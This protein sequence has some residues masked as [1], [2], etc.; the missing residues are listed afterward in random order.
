MS[1]SD[2]SGLAAILDG[3]PRQVAWVA[4]DIMLDEYVMG[5]VRRI[6]PEAPV[7]VVRVRDSQMRLGGAANVAAQIATLGGAASLMGVVGADAA[8]DT[9]LETCAARGIDTRA[10]LRLEAIATTR[11]VRVLG[12]RQQ[13]LRLDWEE[14]ASCPRAVSGEML[15][16]LG[17]GPAPD[18]VI[19]SDY[20]KG[21]LSPQTIGEL[22]AAARSRGVLVLVDPKRLDFTAYRGA[23]VITPNLQ[24][25]TAASGRA[26]EP[27]D[28][29]NK[30]AAARLIGIDRKAL[31]RRWE[32]LMAVASALGSRPADRRR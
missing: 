11:K 4:G 1:G 2:A 23:T 19:L 3:F 7:P 29:G 8:G 10:V 5:E 26:L 32:R 25:L 12:Q 20:A 14:T 28:E 24:E 9:V 18:V 21:F 31:E 6:S 15:R 17:D 27:A 16:R 22:V 13:L 30:S